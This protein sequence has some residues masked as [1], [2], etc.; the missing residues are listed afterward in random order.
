[1]IE[2][3][4]GPCPHSPFP[5]GHDSLLSRSVR[6]RRN[7]ASRSTTRGLSLAELVN[8]VGLAA[9]LGALG[10]YG[11]ARYLQHAK[12][13]EAAGYL[14]AIATSAAEYYNRSDENQ[15]AGSD[16]KAIQAMR[17]FPPSSRVPVPA[18]PLDVR[19]KRYQS[20]LSEWGTSPW[21]DLRFSIAPPQYYA[22]SFEASGSGEAAR[23]TARA[24]GD[25]DGDGV[26]SHFALSV[27]PDATLTARPALQV[28]KKSPEE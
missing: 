14:S 7:I 11:V 5:R 17:H 28:E 3:A 23:A 20:S 16:P 27:A 13:L 1:M 26:T 8:F 21:R 15:P 22:Y 24:V 25:L 12:T 4:S 2:R 9:I 18:D 10:M 6:P 19:G